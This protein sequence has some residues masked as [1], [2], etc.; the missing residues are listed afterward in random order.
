MVTAG[1]FAAIYFL[2]TLALGVPQSR[3]IWRRLKRN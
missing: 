2:L 3:A 1:T